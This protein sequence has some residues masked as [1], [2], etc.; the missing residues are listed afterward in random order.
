[1]ESGVLSGALP[2][3]PVRMPSAI[4]LVALPPSLFLSLSQELNVAAASRLIRAI[5]NKFFLIAMF[6]ILFVK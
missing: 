2:T 4:T 3:V 5:E 6:L 1:M